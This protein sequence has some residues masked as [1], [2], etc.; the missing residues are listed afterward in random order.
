MPRPLK[1]IVVEAD[2]AA[3]AALRFGLTRAG[4]CA[5]PVSQPIS[6]PA[7][8]VDAVRSAGL[9]LVASDHRG[10]ET[11]EKIRSELDSAALNIP[12]LFVGDPSDRLSLE[13]AGAAELVHRDVFLRDIANVARLML[14]ERRSEGWGGSLTE[15]TGAFGLVRA[16]SALGRSG[17]LTLTRGVRRGEVRYFRGEVTSAQVGLIHGQAA[18]H[19]LVLWTE[20]KFEFRHEDVVR[21]QQIPLTADELLADTERFL[22]SIREISGGLSPALVLEI[23][24]ERLAALTIQIPMEVHGVLRMFDGRRSIADIL[25]D[26][27]Y[28]VHETL[29]VAQKGVETNVLRVVP[30]QRPRPTGTAVLAIEQWLLGHPPAE[31]NAPVAAAMQWADLVPRTS[32][33]EVSTLSQI[34][35]V[36]KAMGEFDSAF[37]DQAAAPGADAGKSV[38]VSE[39]AIV[40]PEQREEESRLIAE[41]TAAERAEA[42]FADTVQP[43]DL[44]TQETERVVFDAPSEVTM[45]GVEQV[46]AG[47][48]GLIQQ[49]DL[50]GQQTE[51]VVFDAPPSAAPHV[52]APLQVEDVV[53][54][55][56]SGGGEPPA[57][58][59]EARHQLEKDSPA[60]APTADLSPKKRVRKQRGKSHPQAVPVTSLLLDDLQAAHSAASGLASVQ[61]AATAS[62]D[63]GQA[64]AA[65]VSE[66]TSDAARATEAAFSADEEA[67]FQSGVHQGA[68]QGA[69]S[70][71]DLDADFRRATFWERLAGRSNR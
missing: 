1:V 44:S 57:P 36:T 2:P 29:R 30:S 25:E 37:P 21:R 66:V 40:S 51:R 53:H 46:A 32:G 3:N 33:L 61:A 49:A 52:P 7:F 23:V 20:A 4:L 64:F 60:R 13:A 27:S 38:I 24:A 47:S 56:D 22:D 68:K 34:V 42:E 8:L 50:S 43:G 41:R 9:V 69:E 16:V 39:D 45:A 62:V 58:A 10:A 63:A 5:E 67:F 55:E 19:Q 26:S 28:R 35:P 6:E 18:F 31:Q 17:V 14:S 70:F 11:V 12:I 71:D 48:D 59:T 54:R 65:V 15:M